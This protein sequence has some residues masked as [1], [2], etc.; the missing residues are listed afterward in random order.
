MSAAERTHTHRPLPLPLC[1]PVHTVAMLL[2][3]PQSRG[4]CATFQATYSAGSHEQTP[5]QSRA[6]PQGCWDWDRAGPEDL[7]VNP[8]GPAGR[9]G[10]PEPGP[11]GNAP[12]C[13][14]TRRTSRS[15]RWGLGRPR[16]GARSLRPRGG[17]APTVLS[18]SQ[19]PAVWV[20][21]GLRQCRPCS[22]V[23]PCSQKAWVSPG[24]QILSTN[25]SASRPG[26]V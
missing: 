1:L 14:L 2:P 10:G 25:V 15:H 17:P 24:A 9:R 6:Q 19:K 7:G 3:H 22:A 11:E 5:C 23:W 26:A 18:Y 8:W 4:S 13:C 20:I 21:S 12:K 16:V